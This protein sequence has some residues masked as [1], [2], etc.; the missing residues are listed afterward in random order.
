MQNFSTTFFAVIFLST[1]SRFTNV[2]RTCND[3]G[4]WVCCT[5]AVNDDK[6][7]VAQS[8]PVTFS[9]LR[10]RIRLKNASRVFNMFYRR[11]LISRNPE[12]PLFFTRL[13]IFPAKH[14]LSRVSETSA[15]SN[16]IAVE[17]SEKPVYVTRS[18][19]RFHFEPKFQKPR[20]PRPV[21]RERF[22]TRTGMCLL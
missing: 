19:R 3:I 8:R 4:S 22:D 18:E 17:I 2:V 15:I 7:V 14:N 11:V 1:T 9:V 6:K 5:T 21:T 12:R 20:A 16:L 10:Y 13:K